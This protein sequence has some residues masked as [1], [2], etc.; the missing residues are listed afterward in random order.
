M[1]NAPFQLFGLKVSRRRSIQ[2]TM[3]LVQML[4]RN[5]PSPFPLR[6]PELVTSQ[7]VYRSLSRSGC[8]NEKMCVL[9]G[10]DALARAH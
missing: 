10:F 8:S 6:R 5:F 7:P 1:S 3:A 4:F 9:F 2:K